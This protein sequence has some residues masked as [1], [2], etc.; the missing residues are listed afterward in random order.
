MLCREF[1]KKKEGRFKMQRPIRTT[2]LALAVLM[3]SFVVIT[4]RLGAAQGRQT[5]ALAPKPTQLTPYTPPHKPHWK[6]SEVL[7]QNSG[8]QSW[9]LTVVDDAHLKAQY[10][11]MA[12]GESTPTKFYADNPVWWVV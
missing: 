5:A 4:T 8:K 11:S 9:N 6:L 7:A 2:F 10:I 12:P 3:L 1:S